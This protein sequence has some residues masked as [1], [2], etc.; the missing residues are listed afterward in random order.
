MGVPLTIAWGLV[1]S[2]VEINCL[3]VTTLSLD[4]TCHQTSMSPTVVRKAFYQKAVN[5]YKHTS[6]VMSIAA[7]RPALPSL[8]LSFPAIC[9][10]TQDRPLSPV[11]VVGDG[12]DSKRYKAVY[13]PSMQPHDNKQLNIQWQY[14]GS[15]S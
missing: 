10:N 5:S 12:Y 1:S 15:F 4:K 2:H 14:F 7:K 3:G 11:R 6:T 9:V 8:H 13:I